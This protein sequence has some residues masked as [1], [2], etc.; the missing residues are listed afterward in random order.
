MDSLNL[1]DLTYSLSILLLLSI[2]GHQQRHFYGPACSSDVTPSLHHTWILQGFLFVRLPHRGS[3][4]CWNRVHYGFFFPS[5]LL[6][7]AEG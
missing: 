2:A 7:I 1:P 5:L 3:M 6:Y 4:Q